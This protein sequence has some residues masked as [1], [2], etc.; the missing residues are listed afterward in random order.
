MKKLL[1]FQEVKKQ[2]LRVKINHGSFFFCRK[3]ENLCSNYTENY[4][5]KAIAATQSRVGH[6][7]TVG[8]PLFLYSS[9]RRLFWV[10][11]I[12]N[13]M[14]LTC[15]CILFDRLCQECLKNRINY[16]FFSLVNLFWR[17]VV[18]CIVKH[19]TDCKALINKKF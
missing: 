12:L 6:V 4:Y 10:N 15:F 2:K 8:V 3:I 9:A 14:P 16:V 13:F 1:I 17:H 19:V 11:V 18:N 5:M 7:R